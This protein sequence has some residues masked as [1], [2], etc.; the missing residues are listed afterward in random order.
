MSRN[1]FGYVTFLTSLKGR[2]GLLADVTHQHRVLLETAVAVLATLPFTCIGTH[3]AAHSSNT[4][5]RSAGLLPLP[6]CNMSW[7]AWLNIST[8]QYLHILVCLQHSLC[9]Q[10]WA[11]RLRLKCDGTRAETR[12][13]LSAKRTNPFKSAG[14]SVQS[15]T[16]SRGVYIS[17]S[18]AGYTMFWCSVKGT[19]YPLHSPVSPSPPP[20][21]HS[22]P[23]H[24]TW[25]LPHNLGLALIYASGTVPL[26]H[27]FATSQFQMSSVPLVIQLPGPSGSYSTKRCT[28][29]GAAGWGHCSTKRKVAGSLPDCV[30][31]IFSLT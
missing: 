11:G 22:V 27:Y 7:H 14:A 15:T 26:I 19:G 1:I 23:S 13:R 9:A 16:G 6:F 20:K 2:R 30:I 3:F 25:T 17:G 4:H 10:Q 29:R 8:I 31:G 18:N 21:R 5:T 28:R 24:F 12:F